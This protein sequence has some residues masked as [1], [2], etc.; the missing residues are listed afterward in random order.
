MSLPPLAALR[1][2]EAA[3]RHLNF[4]VAAGELGMTQAAVSHQIRLLE[5]RLGAPLFLRRPRGLALT[6]LGARLASP[7]TEAFDRLREVWTDGDLASRRLVISTFV[8]VAANWLAQRIGRF[9]MAHPEQEVRLES[10]DHVVDFAR[11][12]VDVAIRHGRGDWP[13]LVAVKL[14]DMVFSPM[15]S[16][17]RLAEWGPLERP[18]QLVPLPWLDNGDFM[19]RTWL[20]AAG[21]DGDGHHAPTLPP[22]GNQ[23]HDAR[24]AM[25][26]EGVALLT[27]RFF[28][29]EL[30]TGALVQ[31][32]PIV[33]GQGTAC[34]LVYPSARRNRPAIR[35]LRQFLL[36]EAAADGDG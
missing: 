14:F 16:P 28:R 1:V 32:F 6:D 11:E 23:V 18:E 31:P 10:T 15:L 25:A 9:Q 2:F 34:W 21:I 4:T 19:W 5:G 17:A 3:A 22:L 29:F 30:A 26:G 13:G 20:A 12:E 27:P 36:A 8:S 33:A 35:Q 7:T 24:A